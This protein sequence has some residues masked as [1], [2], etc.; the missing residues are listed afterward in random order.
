MGTY[1]VRKR[2]VPIKSRVFEPDCR[3]AAA[4]QNIFFRYQQEI[5]YV[6]RATNSSEFL[7]AQRGQFSEDI[8]Y[9]DLQYLDPERWRITFQVLFGRTLQLLASSNLFCE[10]QRY[11][12]LSH[13]D[14]RVGC[15]AEPIRTIQK[16]RCAYFKRISFCVLGKWKISDNKLPKF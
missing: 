5:S 3:L 1:I 8:K 11:L 2:I 13:Q 10:V 14:A 6:L 7:F 15:I 12:R 16:L 9:T 4:I